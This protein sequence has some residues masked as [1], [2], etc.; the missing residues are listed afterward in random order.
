MLKYTL[1]VA[2]ITIQ[3]FCRF[4]RHCSLCTSLFLA[5]C[6]TAF[7]TTKLAAQICYWY[8]IYLQW[9]LCLYINVLPGCGAVILRM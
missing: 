7:F 1:Y 3:T 4:C 9:L 8:R 6:E 2:V 5:L